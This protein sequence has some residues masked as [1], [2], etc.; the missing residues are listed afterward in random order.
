MTD[1]IGRQIDNYRIEERI[2]DGGMGTV[3][4]AL[5]VVL[6]RQVALKVMHAHF[7]RQPEFRE[8]LQQEARIASQLDH[9]SIVKIHEFGE[10]PD[11]V[12]YIAMEYIRDGSVREHLS[13]FQEQGRNFPLTRALQ[14]GIQI[15]DA[16][17]YAHRRSIIHR[18]VK[19]GN[20]IFKRT[21]RAE[22]PR[23]APFRAILTDFG[24]VQIL[25]GDRITD[26]GVMMGTPAYM[27]PEQVQG[28]DLDGRSDLYSLGV[29]LYELITGR[30]PFN[31]QTISEAVMTHMRGEMPQSV[32]TSRSDVPPLIDALLMKAL[33]KD[34]ES[35][36]AT[37]AL[38]ADQLRSAMLAL[39]DSP[40]QVI[41]TP[42]DRDIFAAPAVMLEGF[43]LVIESGRETPTRT[44]MM[45]S[46]YTL[47]RSA[48]NDIVLP[49]EGVSRYH[50]Q[51]RGTETGW[52]L[53]DL[54]G[55]G[56]TSVD[57]RR[58]R[59]QETVLLRPQQRV[60]IGPYEM[61]VDGPELAP[62]VP[63]SGAHVAGAA[64]AAAVAGATTTEPENAPLR[65][66]LARR[67]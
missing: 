45:Q 18:D 54:S 6:G 41:I 32:R 50:A 57:G 60:R 36:F 24:L 53:R 65:V 15:A 11:G 9:P 35:R 48:E 37:G 55:R 17:D 4:R 23:F 26:M 59:Y 44:P 66:F 30:L 62:S 27:S 13:R 47:G 49:I 12:L 52:E 16:L 39:D 10:D 58:L 64:A 51:L 42:E 67:R 33:A 25:S 43:D 14:T 2:G 5:D 34:R 8:R 56:D 20:I 1:L 7:A 3:Y 61:Y 22:E 31:F 38:M 21:Q 46:V 19:L 28:E 63:I 29:V 40:T